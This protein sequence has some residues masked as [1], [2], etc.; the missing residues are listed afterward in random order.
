[1]AGGFAHTPFHFNVL[2]N[3]ATAIVW[4]LKL[5]KL[6]NLQSYST[7]LKTQNLA[8]LNPL[9]AA[10]LRIERAE[11]HLTVCFVHQLTSIG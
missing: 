9:H 10:R 1:L 7:S 8:A 3:L 5:E 11:T 4:Q 6:I 2:S